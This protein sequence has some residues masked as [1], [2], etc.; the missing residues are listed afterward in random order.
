MNMETKKNNYSRAQV[1]TIN[2]LALWRS[3]AL[4]L[5]LVGCS[6]KEA[7]TDFEILNEG[8]KNFANRKFDKSEELFRKLLDDHPDSKLR[9]YA[10][11]GLADSLYRDDKFQEASYQ[12]REF[13]DLYPVHSDAVKARFYKGMSEFNE[14]QPADR[15]QTFTKNALEDFKRIVS[16]PD[17][18]NSPFYEE[19]KKKIEECRKLLAENVFFIGKFYFRTASYQ[20]VINRVHD[21]LGEYPGEPYEDEAMFYLA[22]SYYKEDS[23]KKAMVEFRRLIEKYPDSVYTVTAKDRIADIESRGK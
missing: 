11:M 21:L 19:S 16:N 5:L 20:S 15:D 10:M 4:A 17:Y 2:K 9:I 23:L 13:Y 18:A 12:Y 3:G 7:K 14:R 1:T 6:L 8:Q 22:E